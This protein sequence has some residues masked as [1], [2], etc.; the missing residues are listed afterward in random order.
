MLLMRPASSV[1]YLRSGAS[2]SLYLLPRCQ[3]RVSRLWRALTNPQQFSPLREEKS[4]LV[5]PVSGGVLYWSM[6]SQ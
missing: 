6:R 4:C 1:H 3:R 5:C 2:V